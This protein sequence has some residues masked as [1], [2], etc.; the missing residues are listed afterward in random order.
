MKFSKKTFI[1]LALTFILMFTLSFSLAA[2]AAGGSTDTAG[3]VGYWNFDN[4]LKDS[5]GNN[6]DG[7]NI[8]KI[9]YTDAIFGKGAKFDGKSYIEVADSD[10]LD[11]SEAFTMSFWVYKD[12]KKNESD[13]VPFI[14][15]MGDEGKDYPYG[16]YE[17]WPMQATTFYTSEDGGDDVSTDQKLDINQWA[18]VTS[19]YDGKTLRMYINDQMVKS[20]LVSTTIYPSSQPLYIGMSNF[21]NKDW[22]FKGVMDELRIYNKALSYEEVGDLYTAGLSADGKDKLVK[23]NRMVAFYRFEGN[24][25]DL[26]GFG[27]N[28][29][30]INAKGGIKYI[31]G[32]AGK[33]AKLNAAS[34]FE[35]PDSDSLDLDTGLTIGAWVYEENTDKNQPIINKYGMSND[36]Q[37]N[38]YNVEDWYNSGL[39]LGVREIQ[40]MEGEEFSTNEHTAMGKWYYY[41]VTYDGAKVTTYKNGAQIN[42]NEYD[43]TIAHSWQPM[44]IG[45]NGTE[46]FKGNLDELRIYNYAL[47]PAQVKA[48]YKL[49]DSLQVIAADKKTS[50]T[51]LKVKQ[52]VKLTTNAITYV[53]TS[54]T[55]KETAGKDS[56]KTTAVTEKATYTSSNAKVLTVSK[57]GQ[58]TAVAKGTAILKVTYG[59]LTQN[60]TVTVK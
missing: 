48:I 10:S 5:S 52:S 2:N 42:V 57:T 46:F 28:G 11:L 37:Y 9:T 17:W 1:A 29:K 33:A 21:M 18:L 7:I 50:I 30:E 40:A 56:F 60:I 3:L 6:N 31:D 12:A 8:G 24:G 51:A 38:S 47:T 41:T 54:P 55:G 16:M 44:W 58:I 20:E 43:K 27:N 53:F 4:D 36:Y 22:Y 59:S 35:I 19:T 39:Y 26:S 15:K 23:P 32:L 13:G 25:N 49:T 14:A 34:Y 45:S